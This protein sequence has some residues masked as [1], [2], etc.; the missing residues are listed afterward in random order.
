MDEDLP[1]DV[2]ESLLADEDEESNDLFLPL[3]PLVQ[4]VDNVSEAG[5][6]PDNNVAAAFES[7]AGAHVG[8]LDPLPILPF[9]PDDLTPSPVSVM[10]LPSKPPRKAR[11]RTRKQKSTPP[12]T[13]V[14]ERHLFE[15][16]MCDRSLT[17]TVDVAEAA[18][19]A[20]LGARRAKQAQMA[21]AVQG[22]QEAAQ[23]AMRLLATRTKV[24]RQLSAAAAAALSAAE[25]A[26]PPLLAFRKKSRE[27]RREERKR[28]RLERA[29]LEGGAA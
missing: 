10:D 2:V 22:A 4:L 29:S 5:V 27:E 18:R 15:P 14:C 24:H 23:H 11:T 3:G 16:L 20:E 1:W 8:E 17:P 12:A 19:L 7:L 13:T 26:A 25:R 28:R 21:L 6:L 9:G